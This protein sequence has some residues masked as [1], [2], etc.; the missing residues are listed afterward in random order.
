[1][2]VLILA[3]L[4]MG[5]YKFRKELIEELL[6]EKN[7]VYIALPKCKYT[8]KMEDMGCNFVGINL[9][10]RST[11]PIKDFK[12][13]LNYIKIINFIKPD[14]ILTYTIKPNI[15]GGL[16]SR[17]TK[18]PYISN[19]TGLGTSFES[20]GIVKR[21]ILKLYKSALKKSSCVFFQNNSNKKFFIE[22]S[23][24]SS[25]TRLIP[26]SGVNIDQFPYEKYPMSNNE[27]T[28]L[29]IGRIMRAK[30]IDELFEA[31][32]IIKIKY[33]N[34]NLQIIGD[35]EEDY[36]SK[37]KKLE[38]Q[39][40]IKYYGQQDDVRTFIKKSHAIIL[41]SHHEGLANVLLESA[42]S[43][44]PILASKVPGCIETFEEGVTGL[45]FEAKNAESLIEAFLKFINLSY[46]Q[47]KEMGIAGRRKIEREFN[48]NH[49]VNAYMDEIKNSYY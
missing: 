22:N 49:V 9:E 7:E 42:S 39:N 37:L 18:T 47:K 6:K 4:G 30:G 3:N 20:N 32:Q 15:Y 8:E 36:Y 13:L 44:R 35:F 28:F 48:R 27:I 11:N 33:P 14:V 40:V 45:G 31:I 17:I 23:L 21:T 12:L 19:I 25:K 2:K 29:F 41:P 34:I 24:V 10:R 38:I 46:E 5:L 26:G 43:G 16:A 1:M